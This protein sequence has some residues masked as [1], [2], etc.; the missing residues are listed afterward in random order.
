MLCLALKLTV[1]PYR[2]PLCCLS[3]YPE[4]NCVRIAYDSVH[5][6]RLLFQLPLICSFAFKISVFQCQLTRVKLPC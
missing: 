4:Y 6:R 2:F 3:L 5:C 1:K